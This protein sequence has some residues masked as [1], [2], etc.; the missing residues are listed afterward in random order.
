MLIFVFLVA[1]CHSFCLFFTFY[2]IHTS[3][4]YIHKI[5]L[6]ISIH[7][8]LSPISHRLYAQWETPPCGAEP[9]IE[10]VPALQQANALP[11]EP[12]R[13]IGAP[14]MMTA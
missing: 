10:L 5:H 12:R 2:N 13:T 4:N 1:G 3:F 6:S 9:K 8:G 14:L 11:N 7:G